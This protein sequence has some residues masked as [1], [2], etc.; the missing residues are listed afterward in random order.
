MPKLWKTC[1][2]ACQHLV[3]VS[4]VNVRAFQ[5][6]RDKIDAFG[7]REVILSGEEF[8]YTPAPIDLTTDA[9]PADRYEPRAFVLLVCHHEGYLQLGKTPQPV[10]DAEDYILALSAN[11]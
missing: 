10:F 4:R 7:G 8:G 3:D 11:G 5:D 1:S 6:Q 9:V 2:I